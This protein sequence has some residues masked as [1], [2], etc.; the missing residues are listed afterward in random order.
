MKDISNLNS[1]NLSKLKILNIDQINQVEDEY[2][3]E[4]VLI[5]SIIKPENILT[6]STKPF[7]ILEELHFSSCE[8]L[9]IENIFIS[10]SKHITKI[11]MNRVSI[12]ILPKMNFPSLK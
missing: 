11:N 5:P 1:S 2:D 7:D 6:V 4:G 12:S 3:D 10:N 9:N 8:G